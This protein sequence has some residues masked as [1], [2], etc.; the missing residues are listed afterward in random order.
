MAHR[1]V[2]ILAIDGGGVAF[3]PFLPGAQPGDPLPAESGD[4]VV[5]SNRTDQD[6]ELVSTDAPWL[7][8]RIEAG[9]SSPH[10][11]IVPGTSVRY[12]CVQPPQPHLIE[13]G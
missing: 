3:R 5:W 2:E 4:G 10:L 12:R 8:Q 13:V 9:G 7:D 11:F 1:A 6:V